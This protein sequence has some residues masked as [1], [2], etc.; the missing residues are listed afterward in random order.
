[1][2][3][4]WKEREIEEVRRFKYLGYVIMAN[5]GQE[6]QVKERVRKGVAVMSEL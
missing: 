5:G 3:W 2:V 4:K 1:M 6:A